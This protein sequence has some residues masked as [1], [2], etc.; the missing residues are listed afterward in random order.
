MVKATYGCGRRHIIARFAKQHGIPLAHGSIPFPI[1]P[2]WLREQYCTRQRA[3][4]DIAR[5]LGTDQM[6]VNNALH[7]LGIPARP[8]GVTSH[9]HMIIR[10]DKKVVPREVRLAVEDSLHG[11]QR[12]HRFQITMAFPSIDTAAAYL[13]TH[14]GSLIHQ[15]QRLEHDVGAQLFH[16]AARIWLTRPCRTSSSCSP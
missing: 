1:D 7:R 5:E 2:G 13:D 8:S 6:I 9:L 15:F 4:A 11:W 14:R 3:T 10:L 16:R 12:L